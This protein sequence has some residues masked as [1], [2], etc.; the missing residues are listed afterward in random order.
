MSNTRACI[1]LFASSWGKNCGQTSRLSLS[2][3][4]AFLALFRMALDE[5]CPRFERGRCFLH[6]L[7]K[8]VCCCSN[9]HIRFAA[10]VSALLVYYKLKDN[11]RDSGL[12]RRTV[13]RAVQP[14]GGAVPKAGRGAPSPVGGGCARLYRRPKPVGQEQTPS[15]DA[16][17]E[18]SA[19]LLS[20]WRPSPPGTNGS[21]GYWSSSATVWAAG[22]I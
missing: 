19:R 12:L 7:K 11:M 17:A 5:G 10:D 16:A 2:Y 15:L 18:P 6:P 20:I 3:D 13:L 8:R 14:C 22:F 21:A 9:E 1:V 4:L